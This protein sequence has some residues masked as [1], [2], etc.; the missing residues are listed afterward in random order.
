MKTRKAM[1]K[2][3]NNIKLN[4]NKKIRLLIKIKLKKMR[5]KKMV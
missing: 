4:K 5:R 1:I 2:T 3:S